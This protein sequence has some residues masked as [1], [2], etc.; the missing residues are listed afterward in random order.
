MVSKVVW[1]WVVDENLK[2]LESATRNVFRERVLH[3]WSHARVI[4][5]RLLSSGLACASC[6]DF[7][8][9]RCGKIEA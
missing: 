5:L 7:T 4:E 8:S 9:L 6:L 1:D 3:G 2:T